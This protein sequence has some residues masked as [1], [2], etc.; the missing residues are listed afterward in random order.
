MGHEGLRGRAKTE[1]ARIQVAKN[2][3]YKEDRTTL[4]FRQREGE[5]RTP[6]G[7][8]PHWYNTYTK[9]EE[10]RVSGEPVIVEGQYRHEMTFRFAS[11]RGAEGRVPRRV[12]EVL[13]LTDG[14]PV[15]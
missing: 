13:F 7:E 12:V 4:G 11:T 5:T 8:G 1:V 15:R 9:G 14:P 6:V 10:D 3:N 2:Q